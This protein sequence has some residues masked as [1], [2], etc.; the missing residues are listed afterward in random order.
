MAFNCVALLD[1][2]REQINIVLFHT[3]RG[4]KYKD[5]TGR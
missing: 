2:S 4:C 3:M 5:A 1:G